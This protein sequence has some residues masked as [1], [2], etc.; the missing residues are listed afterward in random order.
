MYK[1]YL[2]FVFH[3]HL[4][5]VKHPE[6][7]RV[8]EENW[9][10]E[11]QI[12]TYLPLID[13]FLRL[14][15]EG[16]KFRLTFSVSPPLA[17]MLMDE[18][19]QQRFYEYILRLKELIEK[20]K[21]RTKN[22]V[23]EEVVRFYDDRIKRMES[24]YL[25]Y[26][27][28]ILNALL[29][30]EH[31]G[32][33]LLITTPA[34][35]AFLPA[36][37]VYPEAVSAQIRGGV[38]SFLEWNGSKP[39]GMWLSECGYYPGLDT[40][41]SDNDVNFIIV[42]THAIRMADTLPV[43][44]IY[45]PIITPG[46]VAAFGRDPD[47]SR[48]VWSAQEGYPG[49]YYYREFY[50]DVGF[51]LPIDYIRPYI[52]PSGVRI[53]TGLKYYRITGK[54]DYKEVYNR[55]AALDKAAIHADHFLSAR[56]E[57]AI[58]LLKKMDRPPLFLAPYDA[59]LFGHWWFEGPDWLYYL[60]K[61]IHYNQDIIETITPLD[62]LERHPVNQEAQISLSSWGDRGYGDVW[63]NGKTDWIYPLIYEGCDI[64]SEMVKNTDRY[65]ENEYRILKQAIRELF[66][67]QSSDWAFIISTDTT[68]EYAH[69]RV[70]EHI[71]F[72]HQL[73]NMWK[74]KNYDMEL[75]E[76]LEFRHAIFPNMDP[77]LIWTSPNS[78]PNLP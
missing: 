13:V 41:L 47:A 17:F 58:E 70:K 73:Y 44:D 65:N 77:Y 69:R 26:N 48:Q 50:R 7:T 49:D 68:V 34:T 23:F 40:V 10:F 8:M 38:Y 29:D 52:D 63:I 24:I 12:E 5:F 74:T 15:E 72:L 55:T 75:V 60:F 16:V 14:R 36:Y 43:Y 61:K 3:A 2:S 39:A 30:L 71:Y 66:L 78:I 46:G 1:G 35:H 45:A 42:D 37:Q 53:H 21:H 32:H 57:K 31:S 64:V 6:Y 28:N 54:T 20:E 9:L 18:L 25:N 4:P 19:L 76:E 67:A 33:L 59:E 27:K 22:T 11:A 56:I 51:D 62:Y